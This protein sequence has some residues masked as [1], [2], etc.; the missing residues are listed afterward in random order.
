MVDHG[1]KCLKACDCFLFTGKI[2]DGLLEVSQA[3]ILHLFQMF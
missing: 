2:Y 3:E 1:E